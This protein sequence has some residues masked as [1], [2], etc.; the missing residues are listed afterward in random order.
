MTKLLLLVAFTIAILATAAAQSNRCPATEIEQPSKASCLSSVCTPGYTCKY[1]AVASNYVCCAPA[2]RCPA[3]E[4]EQP[5][6][7]SCLSSV[8]TTGYTCKYSAV[9]SNY[10]CCAP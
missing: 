5:S 7:A 9:A 1:S 6:K 2:N 10:V 3:T 8:C 4:M